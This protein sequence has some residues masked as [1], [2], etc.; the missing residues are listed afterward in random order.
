MNDPTGSEP[1]E[2]YEDRIGSVLD[3]F[4][5]KERY[6]EDGELHVTRAF[7]GQTLDMAIGYLTNLGGTQV[8]ETEVE[9][10]GWEA[11]LS[12][13]QVPVGPHYRLT[14]VTITWRGEESTVDDIISRFWIKSFRAPG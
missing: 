14:E 13:T 7:R 1:T 6:V 4:P 5:P 2:T 9:G 11:S 8:S 10:D 12:A 3:N